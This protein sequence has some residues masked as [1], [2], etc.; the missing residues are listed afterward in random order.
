MDVRRV[1]DDRDELRAHEQYI[2]Q[3]VADGMTMKM[4]IADNGLCCLA[5]YKES[6]KQHTVLIIYSIL[7][8]VSS[9]VLGLCIFGIVRQSKTLRQLR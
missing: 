1:S 4:L 5:I 7:I 9:V 6:L 2:K 3:I 8:L